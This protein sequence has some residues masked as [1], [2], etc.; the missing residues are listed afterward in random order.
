MGK[1][2]ARAY[3]IVLALAALTGAAVFAFRWTIDRAA[4]PNP[5]ILLAVFIVAVA[6]LWVFQR[7]LTRLLSWILAHTVERFVAAKDD[8]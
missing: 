1:P 4:P 2:G 8:E 3:V 5:R 6:G 7:R